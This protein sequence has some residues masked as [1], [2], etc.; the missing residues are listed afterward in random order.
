MRAVPI[1][2][3]ALVLGAV[4]AFFV[5][6]ALQRGD[7]SLATAP[8]V[9]AASTIEPGAR[10]GAIQLRIARWPLGSRP[11]GSFENV[12]AVEGRVVRS[13][14][15]AGEPVLEARLA[16][17]ESRGGLASTLPL[18]KRAISVRVNDVVGVAGF[19]LPGSFVDVLVSSKDSGGAPFSR[20]VLSR[21]RVLAAAQE[22]VADPAKPKVVNAV[23]L[24]LTPEESEKLDL[25]R[26]IGSLSLVLRNELD[27]KI[28]DSGGVRLGDL[29]SLPR[30]E[31]EPALAAA[32]APTRPR[33][34]P[35][36]STAVSAQAGADRRS[37]PLPEEIRGVL[38]LPLVGGVQ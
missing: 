21:V 15:Q 10:L 4:A 22:T 7:T 16:P 31:P 27:T 17:P 34:R 32:P 37:E 6:R 24:E 30:A 36:S 9:V 25:A 3:F 26:T 8:V 2:A 12:Q 20:T 29:V 23:T 35:A 19:A 13:A 14:L 5:A 18:G 28:A 38:R 33:S 11:E 1:I